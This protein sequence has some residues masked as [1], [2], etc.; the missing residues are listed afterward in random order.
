[1]GD[2]ASLIPLSH[3]SWL[4]PASA[5]PRGDWEERRAEGRRGLRKRRRG[6]DE[7]QESMFSSSI[8]LERWNTRRTYLQ[9]LE[10]GSGRG[11]EQGKRRP[12]KTGRHWGSGTSSKAARQNVLSLLLPPAP[13]PHDLLPCSSASG[14]LGVSSCLS[15]PHRR[16]PLTFGILP[17]QLPLLDEARAVMNYKPLREKKKALVPIPRLGHHSTRGHGPGA[18]G[19]LCPPCS[20]HRLLLRGKRLSPPPGLIPISDSLY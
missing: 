18:R 5:A 2:T 8:K 9:N 7:R 16:C 11:C 6:T 4:L 19:C 12:E 1:M 10:C 3:P 14:G 20:L 15:P 13:Q 17:A